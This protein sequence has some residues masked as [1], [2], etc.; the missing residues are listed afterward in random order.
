MAITVVTPDNARGSEMKQALA[1][2]LRDESG[3]V[4]VDSV[5]VLGG[6]MWMSL[7]LAVDVG[8]ATIDVTEKIN[9]RLEY[10]NIVAEILGEYGPGSDLDGGSAPQSGS[11][12]DAGCGN[13]GNPG[14]DKC[15]GNA[16][17]NPNGKGGW[18]EGDRGRSG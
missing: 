13:P 17:E 5:V 4:T 10:S 7:A 9:E 16:G 12:G 15:V 1:K 14:N 8:A 11:D 2:F 6:S 3:A 18:G